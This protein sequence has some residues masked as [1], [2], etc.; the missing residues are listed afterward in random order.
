MRRLFPYLKRSI[1]IK[2]NGKKYRCLSAYFFSFYLIYGQCD[3]DEILLWEN[4]YS[5]DTTFELNLSGQGLTGIIPA[6]IS[7]LENLLF[8]D[9]SFNDLE[10][11]LP[12]QLFQMENLLGLDLRENELQ[13]QIP[14]NIGMLSNLMYLDLSN[15][16]FEGTIPSGI[17]SLTSLVDLSL[18]ENQLTGEIPNSIGDLTYLSS[19][20]LNNNFIYG[21]LPSELG[22]CSGLQY[23]QIHD[24]QLSGEIPMSLCQLD[25]DW[26]SIYSFNISN[27]FL[28]PPYPTCL[29][30]I[31]LEQIVVDCEGV[32]SLWDSL[33][34]VDEV[35][36][37]DMSNFG[38]SGTI[39]PEIGS[40]INLGYL[41]LSNNNLNGAIPSELGE[42]TNLK[43][44]NLSFNQLSGDIP[45]TIG[46]LMNLEEVRLFQNELTGSIPE[47]FGNLNDLIH[48]NLRNNNLNGFIPHTFGNLNSLEILYLHNNNLSGSIPLEIFGLTNLKRLFLNNNQLNGALTQNI[49]NL[50]SIE[51]F[52][53]EK[54]NI[55]GIIPE[56][57]CN[58]SLQFENSLF[59]SLS[60]NMFCEP[61]PYCIEGVQ[62]VQD[63]SNCSDMENLIDKTVNSFSNLKL[64]PNPF[65]TSTKIHF[66]IIRKTGVKVEII[67]LMGR[68]INLLFS[69]SM[70]PGV[71]HVKWV[72]KNS[73]GFKVSPGV[74]FC[75]L[76]TDFNHEITKIILLK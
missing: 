32:V 2:G 55:Y 60:E 11:S 37:L 27:N 47:E 39:P 59:F 19:I 73:G 7:H 26:Q 69:G 50:E 72:G 22:N 33:F 53:I 62:G 65:N 15:N 40:F 45:H 9:L 1:L 14:E 66:N 54:N 25:L 41:N 61:Y 38:L 18:Y 31:N 8:L 4:C 13:G 20:R 5:A 16:N 44:L 36:E 12:E 30:N 17:G 51:R 42:L 52:R 56:E 6:Q 74:Y 24:N 64:Y 63:T 10:G 29:D 28:C 58:L 70:E 48:L 34:Y 67:D 68:Q 71:R 49:A 75:R 43:Y 23:L 57:I 76:E 3:H 35:V 46:N 21:E